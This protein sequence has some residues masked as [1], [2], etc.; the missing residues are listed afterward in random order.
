[1]LPEGFFATTRLLQ[2]RRK[3]VQCY[4]AYA[5]EVARELTPPKRLYIASR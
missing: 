1:M 3:E 2:D 5:A 4:L